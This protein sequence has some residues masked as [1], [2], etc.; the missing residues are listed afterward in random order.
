M[1]RDGVINKNRNDHVKT[2]SEFEFLPG[3]FE[4]LRELAALDVLVIVITNQGAIGRGM[5]TFEAVDDIHARMTLMVQAQV[6]RIDDVLYCPH[7][8]DEDCACRKP[9]PGMLKIAA[10]KWQLDLSES[11]LIGDA[12]TDILAGREV[13]CHTVL[14]LTGRTHRHMAETLGVPIAQDLMEAVRSIKPMLVLGG[15]NIDLFTSTWLNPSS[16]SRTVEDSWNSSK[17]QI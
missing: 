15:D 2:W 3:V 14:V 4:A 11:F 5:T 8:P 1:D 9:K 7:R 12:D 13:G 10:E 17:I 16:S 6:G